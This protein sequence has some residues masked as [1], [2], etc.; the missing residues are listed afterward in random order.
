MHTASLLPG[1]GFAVCD[2][3]IQPSQTA[4][5]RGPGWQ[6]IITITLS[7]NCHPERLSYLPRVTQLIKGRTRARTQPAL[8]T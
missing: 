1:C 6:F 3:C 4:C 8:L 7:G 2:P 5:N